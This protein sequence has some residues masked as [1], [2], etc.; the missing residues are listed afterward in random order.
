MATFTDA[1]KARLDSLYKKAG[2]KAFG[3]TAFLR[4]SEPLPAELSIYANTVRLQ[5]IPA[6]PPTA[7]TAT[8]K[9]W[10][11]VAE[12]GDG[13]LVFSRDRSVADGSKWVALP[14]HNPAFSAGS[15]SAE[16]VASIEKGFITDVKGKLYLPLF[17]DGTDQWIP[18]ES[19]ALPTLDPDSGVL[20]F[21]IG[22]TE[23]GNTPADS[24][25][26]K[27][28]QDKGQT[29]K[30]YLATSGTVEGVDLVAIY[31]AKRDAP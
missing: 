17:F 4:P 3:S 5:D 29:L 21:A 24:I 15:A 9:K 22:R 12:D 27:L 26:A 16:T 18:G 14:Q 13:M 6:T 1:D 31:T 7:S 11:P 19:D 23:T 28:Y 30:D 25:K 10:Y 2:G 8:I 20:T